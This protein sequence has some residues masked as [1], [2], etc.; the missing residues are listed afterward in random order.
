[1]KLK[2]ITTIIFAVIALS[3]FG[4]K[5]T[6][7]SA[8][9]SSQLFTVIGPDVQSEFQFLNPDTA[10]NLFPVPKTN[11]EIRR[12]YNYQ[13]VAVGVINQKWEEDGIS[14]QMRALKAFEMRHA[15]R[16]NAR[17]MMQNKDEVKALQKRDQ[18]KYGNPDGP[19]F[20]YLMQK[21]IDKG[22]TV[23][24]AYQSIIDSSST[25]DQGYNADCE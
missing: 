6:S 9:S 23:A 8:S 15:A 19:T 14:L 24:E 10:E 16:V 11:C 21:N 1:M 3:S 18:E 22:K 7:L 20:G 25:T 2:F 4:H 13:V 17:Y 5:V 12:W